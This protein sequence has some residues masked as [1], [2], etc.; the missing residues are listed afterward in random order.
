MSWKSGRQGGWGQGAPPSTDG[1]PYRVTITGLR[2]V[3]PGGIIRN[4][5]RTDFDTGQGFWLGVDSDGLGKFGVGDSDGDQIVWD[6]SALTIAGTGSG[7]TQIDG[8]N[9]QAGTITATEISVSQ[10]S[11]ITANMGTL[12]TGTIDMFSGTWDIDATGFRLNSSEIAG[13]NTGTDQVILSSA[14]GKLTA[15]AG[16]LILDRSGME[17]RYDTGLLEQGY[18]LGGYGIAG[19]GGII[20]PLIK[21]TRSSST[22]EFAIIKSIPNIFAIAYSANGGTDGYSTRWRFNSDGTFQLPQLSTAPASP[23]TGT[24]AWADGTTWNPGAG[25]GPY[26]YDGSAWRKLIGYGN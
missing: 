19:Y 16:Q 24:F 22:E 10:L 8:G 26:I 25:A 2:E 5:A 12:T 9:I 21:F 3:V 13:Q 15:G 11:A 23:D 14:T 6:G 1:Q 7:I 18:G 20:V 4:S 17:F